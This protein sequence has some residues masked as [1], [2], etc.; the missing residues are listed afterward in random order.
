[1]RFFHPSWAQ[2]AG[3]RGKGKGMEDKEDIQTDRH[4][5]PIKPKETPTWN[6][7]SLMQWQFL[8]FPHLSWAIS[9]P[10]QAICPNKKNI[11]KR[12]RCLLFPWAWVHMKCPLPSS[13]LCKKQD[14]L[15]TQNTSKFSQLSST[16]VHGINEVCASATRQIEMKTVFHHHRQSDPTGNEKFGPFLSLHP[17]STLRT[18]IQQRDISIMLHRKKDRQREGNRLAQD[19][20]QPQQTKKSNSGLLTSCWPARPHS[21]KKHRSLTQYSCSPPT[22]L[23]SRK[24][25]WFPC[26][27]DTLFPSE[28]MSRLSLLISF[29]SLGHPYHDS[30][31]LCPQPSTHC[32]IST[33]PAFTGPVRHQ[34]RVS[35]TQRDDLFGN[36][37]LKKHFPF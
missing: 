10:F 17:S 29:P 24:I 31:G 8:N 15:E 22:R 26:S 16:Q 25:T 6:W 2:G 14:R 37:W 21:W 4:K 32:S 9:P 27:W 3:R 36:T 5:D 20:R 13:P 35:W 11:F 23:S 30:V 7:L 19:K 33:L 34:K 28:I 1:M 18:Q 12:K